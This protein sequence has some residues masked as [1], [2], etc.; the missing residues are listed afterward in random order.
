MGGWR[1]KVQELNTRLNIRYIALSLSPSL[2]LSL[3]L[4]LSPLPPSLPPLSPSLLSLPFIILQHK[5][6]HFNVYPNN[7]KIFSRLVSQLSLLIGSWK[8][9]AQTQSWSCLRTA[10]GVSVDQHYCNVYTRTDFFAGISGT[11]CLHDLGAI[12]TT[13]DSWS[14]VPHPQLWH[15]TLAGGVVCRRE[16]QATPWCQ[17]SRSRGAGAFFFF[18][19]QQRQLRSSTS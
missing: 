14:F 7:K 15:L 12:R 5:L 13:L 17:T 6:W 8:S 1:G 4:S 3:S 16:V 10:G 9:L 11:E 18:F 19:P 2:S